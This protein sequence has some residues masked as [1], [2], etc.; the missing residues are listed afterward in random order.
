MDERLTTL[1]FASPL[2]W[3]CMAASSRGLCL[4]H[5]CGTE[6][7]SEEHVREILAREYPGCIS[8]PTEDSPLLLQ[9]KEAVLAY[10]SKGSPLPRIPLD[11]SKGTLFRRDVWEALCRIPHGETRS[12]LEIARSLGKPR[13]P[14]A[15]GQACGSNP[16]ALF[17]P[18]HRVLAAGGR[19]GGYAGG[20]DI[21]RTLLELEGHGA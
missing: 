16:I 20:L 14:R 3:I 9:A 18:C 6:Q 19:L 2:G 8:E 7:P 4:L 21:K 1:S 12:Y 13:A 17:V 11:M 10:L 5:F 15:V